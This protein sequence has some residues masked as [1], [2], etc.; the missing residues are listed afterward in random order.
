M[1]KT[2]SNTF[3]IEQEK[4]KHIITCLT[5][6]WLHVFKCL[7]TYMYRFLHVFDDNILTMLYAFLLCQKSVGR[8]VS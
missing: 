2:P 1:I 4:V 7:Y 5:K 3:N 8:F 6:A